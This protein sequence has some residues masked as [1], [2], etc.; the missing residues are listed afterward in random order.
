MFECL[1]RTKEYWWT[2]Y[3]GTNDLYKR[4]IYIK[5]I[6]ALKLSFESAF[7]IGMSMLDSDNRQLFPVFCD[8]MIKP[9]TDDINPEGEILSLVR[10]RFLKLKNTI[11]KLKNPLDSNAS[12]CLWQRLVRSSEFRSQ[13]NDLATPICFFDS[14]NILCYAKELLRTLCNDW[15]ITWSIWMAIYGS[16]GD[17]LMKWVSYDTL[18]S[19]TADILLG[20]IKNFDIFASILRKYDNRFSD[21]NEILIGK[22]KKQIGFCTNEYY[23]FEMTARNTQER[24]IKALMESFMNRYSTFPPDDE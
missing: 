4:Q 5:K 23:W 21:T 6:M 22:I 19:I 24:S 2:K 7:D 13:L 3:L 8:K 15:E 17:I 1:K 9:Y 14:E 11:D 18:L 10:K 12:F 16:R 20:Y